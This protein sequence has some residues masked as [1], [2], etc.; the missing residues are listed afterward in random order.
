MANGYKLIPL[1]KF[2]KMDKHDAYI[3][4]LRELSDLT[5]W[6]FRYGVTR[7]NELEALYERM[8]SKKGYARH[9]KNALKEESNPFPDGYSFILT[10]FINKFGRDEIEEGSEMA[11][12]L[13]IYSEALEKMNKRRAKGM[14]KDLD[15]PKDIAME[16][17]M[18]YPGEMLNKYNAWVFTREF[19]RRLESLQKYTCKEGE[20]AEAEGK[21][22]FSEFDLAEP[23]F[24]KKLFKGFFGK[25]PETLVRVYANML[26]D[27]ESMKKNYTDSQVKLFDNMTALVLNG[28][29]KLPLKA[30]K[31][32]A[33]MYTKRRDEDAKRD[34]DAKR[35]VIVSDLVY[36]DC[37]K[38][39]TVFNPDE[40]DF[41]AALKEE[42]K[43]KKKGKKDK[44]KKKDKKKKKN[45]K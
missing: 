20:N 30:V 38:L 22:G 37:P 15:M 26:L 23:K 42:K 29:E 3:T 24:L 39:V 36:E 32:I 25:D 33:D 7:R 21:D 35:R 40:Y 10:D 9:I 6:Y 4:V 31:A 19:V 18:I 12:V 43:G 11:E 17:A 1:K 34:K 16:I 13:T 28:I 45:K 14:A 27:R 2:L 5:E 44:D 41:K 8:K